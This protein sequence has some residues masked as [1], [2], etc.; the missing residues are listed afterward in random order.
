MFMCTPVLTQLENLT[1]V[2]YEINN[3]LSSKPYTIVYTPCN[4]NPCCFIFPQRVHLNDLWFGNSNKYKCHCYF[5]LNYLMKH[6]AIHLFISSF[7][8]HFSYEVSLYHG[9]SYLNC[10]KFCQLIKISPSIELPKY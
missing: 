5:N 2:L 9:S 10:Q 3:K 4:K 1:R 8:I 6:T 7:S